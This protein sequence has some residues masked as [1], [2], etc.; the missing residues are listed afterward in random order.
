MPMDQWFVPV[1]SGVIVI[2]WCLIA[3]LRGGTSDD[4]PTHLR[5]RVTLLDIII[6]ACAV[7]LLISSLQYPKLVSG[8]SVRV[9]LGTVRVM[10]LLSGAYILWN[11]RSRRHGR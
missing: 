7:A 6:V 10:L 5:S 3:F 9:A 8:E 11:E 4:G 2:E 1:I